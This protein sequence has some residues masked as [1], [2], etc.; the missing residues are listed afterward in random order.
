MAPVLD[1]L[2][3]IPGLTF[4]EEGHRYEFQDKALGR[5]VVP[6][7]SA[8]LAATEAKAMNWSHWRKR[9]MQKGLTE[10]EERYAGSLWP[11]AGVSL[12]LA[13]ADAFMEWWR[14]YRA[15]V[16]TEFHLLA[17]HALL[18]S[19]DA[20]AVCA[21]ATGIFLAWSERFYPRIKVVRIS[22]L[23]LIHFT[24]FYCGTPDLL[25]QLELEDGT[26]VWALVDWKTQLPPVGKRTVKVRQEW[27][28]QNGAY[29]LLLQSCYGITIDLAINCILWNGGFREKIWNKADLIQGSS[30]F[31]GFL[32]EYHA[33][34]TTLGSV[35]SQIALTALSS[36][37]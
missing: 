3:A 10:E 28:L 36:L 18:G 13:D 30:K 15:N 27:L 17:Q 29:Y 21:E 9:L 16:G 7:T 23:P 14:N 11:A 22:E 37:Y 19:R 8:V 5:L 31:L 4:V 12:S 32:T 6:S 20:V 2:P 33:R 1:L 26:L 34:Q 35:P 24:G 25:A